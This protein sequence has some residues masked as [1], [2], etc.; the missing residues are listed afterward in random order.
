MPFLCRGAACC[1]PFLRR[2]SPI[3]EFHFRVVLWVIAQ[4]FFF[5]SQPK[6]F[7]T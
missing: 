3:L 7:V 1:A 6:L 2:L 4:T 5:T